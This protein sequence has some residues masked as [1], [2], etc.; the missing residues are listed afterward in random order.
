MPSENGTSSPAPPGWSDWLNLGGNADT[1]PAAGINAD[2][3]AEVFAR[4]TL[5]RQLVHRWEPFAHDLC[6]YAAAG[7]DLAAY[8]VVQEA[9]T[10]CRKHAAGGSAAVVIR[11]DCDW[12]ELQIENDPGD[13]PVSPADGGHGLSRHAR[14]SRAVCGTFETGPRADGGFAVRARL[15]RRQDATL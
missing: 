11:Y 3:R 5:N 12:A 2:G 14:A 8:R 7:P 4:P 10:N 13:V 6:R 15:P 1:A 9:L